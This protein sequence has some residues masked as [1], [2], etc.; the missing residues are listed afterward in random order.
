MP[1]SIRRALPFALMLI[2]ALGSVVFSCATTEGPSR[3]PGRP[4]YVN[5]AAGHD[6]RVWTIQSLS[7]IDRIMLIDQDDRARRAELKPGAW[8][9]DA[10]TTELVLLA[11]L[12]YKS[13][14]FHIE[15]LP[16]SPARFVL[17]GMADD[18]DFFVAVA[19]RSAIRG[20][21]YSLDAGHSVLVFRED[22]DP[23]T[24]EFQILYR[25]PE[26]LS[27][28][29]DWKPENGD[30]YAY[31][32]AQH[33]TEVLAHRSREARTEYYLDPRVFESGKPRL[34]LRLPS[35]EEK[36]AID[37]FAMPVTKGRFSA[38]DSA[39]SKE[40]GFDVRTPKEISLGPRGGKLKGMGKMIEETARSGRLRRT[41]L[42]YYSLGGP[43]QDGQDLLELRLGDGPLSEGEAVDEGLVIERKRLDL[44]AEVLRE[45]VW[46]CRGRPGE[47]PEVVDLATY[48]WKDRGVHFQLSCDAADCAI[49]ESAI[50]QIESYRARLH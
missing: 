41:V 42:A 32:A 19:G 35:P 29:G 48:S 49:A 26:G 43:P 15:G 1:V 33:F 13:P 3:L 14:I 22:F 37:A 5:T 28:F 44:G 38:T 47:L 7:R 20:Y 27:S 30:A 9:Y 6:G 4:F 25:T 34:V 31:L 11:A 8:R 10:S 50:I 16:A 40:V 18:E 45:R 17:R 21:D 46:G 23:R 36:A 39:I 12:P 2:L 24:M